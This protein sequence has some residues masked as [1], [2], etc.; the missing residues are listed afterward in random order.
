M[1]RAFL[2]TALGQFY[3]PDSLGMHHMPCS[4]IES[5][6]ESLLAFHYG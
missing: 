6:P 3:S 4:V 5:V 2:V 1:P